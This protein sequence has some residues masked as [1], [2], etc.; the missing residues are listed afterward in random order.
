MLRP[1]TSNT[2]MYSNA[3]THASTHTCIFLLGGPCLRPHTDKYTHV[4][5]KLQE[6]QHTYVHQSFLLLGSTFMMGFSSGR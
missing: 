3:Q 5:Q 1:H 4:F 2:H 6:F